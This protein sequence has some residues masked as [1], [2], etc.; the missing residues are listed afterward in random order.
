[1]V[2]SWTGTIGDYAL[3]GLMCAVA[4]IVWLSLELGFELLFRRVFSHGLVRLVFWTLI[5]VA[6]IV[7]FDLGLLGMALFFICLLIFAGFWEAH[8]L[9]GQKE[10]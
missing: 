7:V 10:K 6:G 8:I 1:M 5:F 4:V 2:K 9:A 3:Y